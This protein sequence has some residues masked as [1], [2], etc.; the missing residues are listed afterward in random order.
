MTENRS[1]SQQNPGAH[2]AN[3]GSAHGGSAHGK[4]IIALS[5]WLL[6]TP[7]RYVLDWE[8]QQFDR[9]VVDIFGFKA[10]QVG[11]L[12]FPAL[13]ANRMP[14]VFSVVEPFALPVDGEVSAPLVVTRLEELPFAAQSLDLLVL[15][16]A[17]E[18]AEDPHQVLREVERVLIPEGQVVISGFNPGSLWGLRQFIGS[19]VGAPFLPP[20]AQLLTLPRLNDWLKLLSFEVSPGCY[21]CYRP[22]VR[23]EKWLT[24]WRFMEQAGD[25]W[26]PIF[27]AVYT[28]SAIKRVRGMRLI[29]P[30]WREPVKAA[31]TLQPVANRGG[32]NPRNASKT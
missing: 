29:G 23:S 2:S 27:G 20:A 19:A 6:T 13:R 1:G 8:Q 4:S 9:L 3:G 24:R 7:G 5:E 15:P 14:F 31:R 25:R 26:W 32:L 12:A 21:G 16:H 18:F 10:A 30:A 22:P 11:L 17:L 28:I